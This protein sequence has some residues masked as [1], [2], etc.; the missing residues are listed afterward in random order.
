[1]GVLGPRPA[2]LGAGSGDPELL[3]DAAAA[4]APAAGYAQVS[5]VRIRDDAVS[6][7]GFGEV[8]E[9]SRFEIGSV[10]KT[11]NSL[12][13]ADAVNRGEVVLDDPLERHLPELQGTEVGGVTLEELVTHRAGLPTLAEVNMVQVIAQSLANAPLSV[14]ETTTPDD[15]LAQAC[16][17]TLQNRGTMSYSNLGSALLGMALARAA[18][19]GDWGGYAQQRLFVPLGMH[20]TQLAQAGRPAADL[21]PPHQ[22]NGAATA[23]WTGTGYAPAGIGVTSTAA[24]MTKYAQA[25]L[26]GSAPGLTGELDPLAARWP[27]ILDQQMALG[28]MITQ[29]DDHQVAWHNGGTGGMRSML[30]IDR[31]ANQATIVLTNI[32]KDVTGAGLV[33]L[34]AGDPAGLATPPPINFDTVG[35]V[36]AGV[37]FV[38]GFG[39]AALTGRS[40]LRLL[41]AGSAAAGALLIWAVA[42]PWDWTAPWTYGLAVGTSVGAAIVSGLRWRGLAWAPPSRPIWRRIFAI[43]GLAIGFGWAT[44]MVAMAIWVLLIAMAT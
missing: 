7:A 3:A 40:R 39:L 1:M 29:I 33:L 13:L 34:G 23:A 15:L 38:I 30:T 5:V 11:F 14:Y 43:I 6:W 35:W 19:F 24:D 37:V 20:D 42:A 18:E 12:L 2:A 9:H 22:A 28:W 8:T 31:D 4:L 16:G 10:T 21:L 32:A 17:L 25:I 36:L 26:A 44:L 27:A 41:A